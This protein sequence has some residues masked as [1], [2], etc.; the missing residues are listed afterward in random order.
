MQFDILLLFAVALVQLIKYLE[1]KSLAKPSVN[2]NLFLVLALL[3]DG[4]TC[5]LN[6]IS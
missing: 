6:I 4:N 5:I 3:Y 2:V 1:N